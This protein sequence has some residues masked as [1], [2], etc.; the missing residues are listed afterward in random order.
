MDIQK[1]TNKSMDSQTVIL[2]NLLSGLLVAVTATV[3]VC[4]PSQLS[5]DWKKVSQIYAWKMAHSVERSEALV[6]VS[7]IPSHIL[8]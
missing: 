5:R 6:G 7:M 1:N 3:T 4:S 2:L 8:T